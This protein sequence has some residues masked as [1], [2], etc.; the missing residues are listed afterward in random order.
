MEARMVVEFIVTLDEE[1]ADAIERGGMEP[2]DIDWSYYA[3]NFTERDLLT[4]E[5]C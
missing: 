3:D 2:A 5:I 1:D 4:A